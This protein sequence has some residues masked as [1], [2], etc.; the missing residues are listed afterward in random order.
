MSTETEEVI[1][2]EKAGREDIPDVC[3]IL[4]GS[5]PYVQDESSDWTHALICSLPDFKFHLY[6]LLTPGIPKKN[7][8]R[9]PENVVGRTEHMIGELPPGVH[10][11]KHMHNFPARLE[12][13]LQNLQHRKGGLEDVKKLLE[14]LTPHRDKLGRHILLDA[15]KSWNMLLHMYQAA[16]PKASFSAYF[17]SWRTMAGDL[18]SV[19]LGPLPK[20]GVYHAAS[21]GYAGLFLAR[22]ALETGRPA[23]LTEYGVYADERRVE[24]AMAELL[25]DIQSDNPADENLSELPRDLWVRTFSSYARACYQSCAEIITRFEANQASQLKDDA[26]AGKL[27]V[28]PNGIDRE[29]FSALEQRNE[30][31]PPTVA[32]I[33]P[34]API[35]DIKTF[36]RSVD[37][38]RRLTPELSAWVL[39]PA[40]EDPEYFEECLQLAYSLNLEGVLKFK[41]R[42]NVEKYPAMI[43][44]VVL[45]SIS[46]AQPSVILEAGA[47]GVPCVAT[48]VGC[49]RELIMGAGTEE[50]KL[51]PG[52]GI[53]PLADPVATAQA[54]FKLI[55]DKA[56]HKRCSQA[57]K[58]RVERYYSKKDH[59]RAYRELYHFYLKQPTSPQ[60][61]FERWPGLDLTY[62]S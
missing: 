40:G 14:A 49:C 27:R 18:Y 56:R 16:Q 32:L 62:V 7:A 48:D 53:T 26:P 44:V 55:D 54:C 52:G 41:D 47:A 51:G 30:G 17:R 42:V 38:L 37:V 23:L 3:L 11:I 60:G 22:T 9:V 57:L 58:T 28:I 59:D 46:E 24:T 36:I 19:L 8:Y 43:D 20:A 4:E 15:W 5:Y 29:R 45:T 39:G 21:T 35:K 13:P 61:A 50:P 6:L 34:V 10:K 2:V 12:E 25:Y 33:G 1:T 31:R